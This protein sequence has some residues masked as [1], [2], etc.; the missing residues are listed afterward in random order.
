[1]AHAAA[2][3]LHSAPAQPPNGLR[4][5]AQVVVGAIEDARVEQLLAREL[6][7]VRAWFDAPLRAAW[8]ADGLSFF[9]LLSRLDLALHDERC[10]DDHHWVNKAR[11]AFDAARRAHG[12]EDAAAFRRLASILANDL[13]QMRVRHEPRQLAV[14]APYRDDHSHLWAHKRNAEETQNLPAPEAPPPVGRPATASPPLTPSP[15]DEAAAAGRDTPTLHLY[16]EWD[17]RLERLR[18]DWCTL[19]EWAPVQAVETP[20][21]AGLG[22]T[23][24]PSRLPLPSRPSV[25]PGR[26]LRRQFE[27]DELDLDAAIDAVLSR[28]LQQTHDGPVFQRR[29]PQQPPCSLLLLLDSSLSTADQDAQG[30][31][32]LAL[33][34]V[35]AWQ[36]ARTVLAAR[37]RI[38]IHAFHSDSRA[39]VHYRRLLDFGQALDARAQARLEALQPAWSTR[40]GAALRH[41]TRLLTAEPAERRAVLVLSDGAPSDIDAHD[42]RDLVE[43]ARQAVREAAQRGLPV[44][45]LIVDPGAAT[46][47]RRIFGVH[48]H[49]VLARTAPLQR[50]LAALHAHI[51]GI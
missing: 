18:P 32:L 23:R 4:P 39:R 44:Y 51:S 35:A 26:R 34:Q 43:D 10:P 6:P 21:D 17:R 12:L 19:H 29:A 9:A 7:G 1:M 8:Q 33:E 15:R 13:G 2:H 49:R 37:G 16:P 25:G 31:S 36:L 5:L 40:L 50:Q 20:S 24:L 41:A 38:A 42:P 45:G 3:L 46:C 22:R 28:R 47:A 48:R 14:P 30:R 11:T 27:G